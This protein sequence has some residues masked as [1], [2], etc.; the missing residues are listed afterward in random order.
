VRDTRHVS[1]RELA[2]WLGVAEG[3][4][5]RLARQGR[6][7]RAGEGRYDLQASVQT[8][9][10]YL[11]EAA[12]GRVGDGPLDPKSRYELARARK[13]EAEAARIEGKSIPTEAVHDAWGRMTAV[14][15]SRLLGL[16]RIVAADAAAA[17]DV[18][19]AAA[20]L[21][22]AVHRLMKDISQE[23]IYAVDEPIP[24]ISGSGDPAGAERPGPSA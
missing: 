15:R 14:I 2:A 7:V 10:R 12:Q 18:E 16:P 19:A 4:V 17:Q 1:A 23:P 24:G 11:S 13:A 6:V 20:V 22:A 21:T 8:Y 9:V 5:R 3:H